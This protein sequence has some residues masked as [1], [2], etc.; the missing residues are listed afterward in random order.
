MSRLCTRTLLRTSAFSKM[1]GSFAPSSPA[2]LIIRLYHDDRR[3]GFSGRNSGGYGGR[4]SGGYSGRNSGGYKGK[5]NFRSPQRRNEGEGDEEGGLPFKKS[6]FTKV[7]RVPENEAEGEI[8]LASL[9]DEGI[10]DNMLYKS[11]DRMGF[12]ALTPVQQKTI[13]PILATTN[14][15]I[16]RAKTGTGKTLAFLIPMFEHL[17][18]NRTDS[19]YMVKCVVVAPTRDLALQIDSEIQKIHK[20]NYGLQ[21]FKSVC[22]IGGTNF[23]SSIKKMFKERPNIIVATPGRL[24]DVMSKFSGK[25]FKFV[26]FKILDEADRLLEIGFKQDL[27]NISSQLNSINEKGPEHIRTLLFSATLDDRVQELANDIMNREECLFLDTV[28]KNEPEAH[29]KIDQHLVISE[30]FAHNL[31][32]PIEEIKSQLA[33]NENLKAILFVPTVKFAKFFC[34]SLE[35]ILPDFPI[36]EFHGKIE[37]RR[38]TRIVQE[39]KRAKRGLLVSTDVGAR[40]MDFPNIDEVFQIGVPS[41][42]ANYIHRI[43]RTARGGKEGRATIYLC[44]DELPFVETLGHEKRVKIEKQKDYT[45]SEEISTEFKETIRG[46]E[47]LNDALQ[48]MLSYYKSCEQ[49]YGFRSDRIARQIAKTYGTLLED[50]D[51]KMHTTKHTAALR[52]G[53]RGRIVDELFDLGYR[54]QEDY[55]DY[56]PHRTSSGN[57]SRSRT[58]ED[59]NRSRGRD[60]KDDHRQ[61]EKRAPYKKRGYNP[62]IDDSF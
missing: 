21:K 4:N 13:K 60:W 59:G 52:F 37:Q 29:E 11:I 34:R 9:K 46:K 22:L 15:V 51:S 12:P 48:S 18:A 27:E 20:N 7:V 42:L 24:Q 10:I 39:F 36:L 61:Y 32:A 31:Y 17:L 8:T 55:D 30:K 56:T 50:P 53:L 47:D 28:D 16:A 41:E 38:R 35:Q 49:A 44:K 3:G 58:F 6:K 25:F 40:G 54:E 19:Q 5:N 2:S 62:R 33:E 23:D 14:D 43:G 1:I 26:D 45:P 57:R